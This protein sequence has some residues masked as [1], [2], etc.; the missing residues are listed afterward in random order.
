MRWRLP[1]L[2]GLGKQGG[3]VAEC[4]VTWA[5]GQVRRSAAGSR[6]DGGGADDDDDDDACIGG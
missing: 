5:T 2:G 1:K 6:M 4:R 3:E